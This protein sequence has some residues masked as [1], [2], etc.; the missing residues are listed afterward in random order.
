[1]TNSDMEISYTVKFNIDCISKKSMISRKSGEVNITTDAVP[2][3]L[4]YSNDLMYLIAKEM[5]KKLNKNI[6]NVEII[7]VIKNE[8]VCK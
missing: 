7:N 5:S 8:S 4:M 2:E 1:M 3:D 6:F